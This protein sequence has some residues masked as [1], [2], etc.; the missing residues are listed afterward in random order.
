MKSQ[1]SYLLALFVANTCTTL[2]LVTA[3]GGVGMAAS[4]ATKRPRQSSAAELFSANN[5]DDLQEQASSTRRSRKEREQEGGHKRFATGKDL[6]NLRS[7]IESLRN[8]LQW[9]E[10]LKDET[11]IQSLEKA[12]E[13]GE[14][15]DPDFMYAKARKLIAHTKQMKDATQEEKDALIEK[16]TDVASSARDYLPQF[17]LGGLWVGQ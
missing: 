16:W 4:S 14:K 12:I 6:K 2:P 17:S 7:D 8:N 1:T 9:A 3:F 11:R 15:R 13:K 10:A 5:D